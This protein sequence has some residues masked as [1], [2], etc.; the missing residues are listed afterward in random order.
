MTLTRALSSF[1]NAFRDG[2]SLA[3]FKSMASSTSSSAV[4][5]FSEHELG[6]M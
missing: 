2:A 6:D 4:C 1:V 5:S 3:T